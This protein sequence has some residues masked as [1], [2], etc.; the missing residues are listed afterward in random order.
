[1]QI[2]LKIFEYFFNKPALFRKIIL[3]NKTVSTPQKLP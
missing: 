2:N 1:M 3:Y